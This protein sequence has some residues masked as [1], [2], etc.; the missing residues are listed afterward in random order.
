MAILLDLLL[1]NRRPDLNCKHHCGNQGQETH[2]SWRTLSQMW[3]HPG[4]YM[5]RLNKKEP[6][7]GSVLTQLCPPRMY[8]K[9]ASRKSGT[10]IRQDSFPKSESNILVASSQHCTVFCN[11]PA[12]KNTIHKRQAALERVSAW[13]WARDVRGIFLETTR[14][15]LCTSSYLQP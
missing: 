2:A 14:P 5:Q 6:G 10:S 11:G 13:Q 8:S 3:C 7:L 4:Q 9:N 15:L 12:I 1:K